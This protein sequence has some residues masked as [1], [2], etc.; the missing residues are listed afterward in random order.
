MNKALLFLRF[1]YKFFLVVFAAATLPFILIKL[2]G[3]LELKE[4]PF[5]FIAILGLIKFYL[6]KAQDSAVLQSVVRRKLPA[7]ASKQEIV[8]NT[9]LY[10]SSQDAVLLVNLVLILILNIYL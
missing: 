7:N 6:A 10:R 9:G 4:L 5:L 3:A 2:Y 1:S 8:N